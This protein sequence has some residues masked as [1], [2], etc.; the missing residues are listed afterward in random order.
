MNKSILNISGIGILVIIILTVL[1]T[2]MGIIPGK[3]GDYFIIASSLII[4]IIIFYFLKLKKKQLN[5]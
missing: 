1:L 5:S 4:A 3:L 2:L